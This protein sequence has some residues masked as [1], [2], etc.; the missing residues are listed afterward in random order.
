MLILIGLG[1]YDEKDLT[2]RGIEQ[3]KEADQAYMELYTSKWNGSIKN[4]EKLLS[5]TCILVR[6]E[7]C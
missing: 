1:L 2:L 5:G 3:A 6:T 4:L 7:I